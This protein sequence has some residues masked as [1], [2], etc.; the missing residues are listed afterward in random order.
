MAAVELVGHDRPED[1]VTEE[2]EPLVG[3]AARLVPRRVA[4]YAAPDVV[5]ERVEQAGEVSQRARR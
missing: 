1:G 2:L 3:V 5:R 4:E